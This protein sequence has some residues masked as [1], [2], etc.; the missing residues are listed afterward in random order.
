MHREFQIPLH[1][2]EVS[3]QFPR[4]TTSNF[5]ELFAFRTLIASSSLTPHSSPYIN[6]DL[7]TKVNLQH[8]N[9]SWEAAICIYIVDDPYSGT[10]GGT[11]CSNI[12]VSADP[13]NFDWLKINAS[14]ICEYE[15]SAIDHCHCTVTDGILDTAVWWLKILHRGTT[16][17]LLNELYL[18]WPVTR[19]IS[20]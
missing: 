10:D 7:W 17:Q 14:C 19:V 2:V 4:S 5:H 16:G 15:R 3:W 20:L 18:Q 1:T 9:A 11:T 6:P 8:V 13:A 12:Y